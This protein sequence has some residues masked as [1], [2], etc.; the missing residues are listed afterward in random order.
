L[1]KASSRKIIRRPLRDIAGGRELGDVTTLRE[2]TLAA[3]F[4][5][6]FAER[7]DADDG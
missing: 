4:T 2:T 7:R 3:D 6:R 1:Q 5:G